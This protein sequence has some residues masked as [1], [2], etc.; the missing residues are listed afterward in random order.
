MTL[1]QAL[2]S[3]ALLAALMTMTPGLDTA[4]VLRTTARF[5][6]RAGA[7][8]ALGVCT[9]VLVWAVDAALGVSALLTASQLAY[10]VVRWCGVA[11]MLW[12][13]ARMLWS[14]ITGRGHGDEDAGTGGDRSVR[15]SYRQGLQVNLLNPKVGAFYVAALP[16]FL[17][18]GTSPVLAGLLLG[19][20]HNLVGLIWFGLIVLLVGR[21][22]RLLSGPVAGRWIDAVAGTA[23]IA[24]GLRLGL[25]RD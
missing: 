2:V 7:A 18:Q 24:F 16:Q 5:G 14:G 13:G 6:R 22:R 11:Y 4:L 17:P 9:G 23:V 19:L 12:L 10:T 21:V 15:A 1:G 3:F 8:S 25:V 20:V